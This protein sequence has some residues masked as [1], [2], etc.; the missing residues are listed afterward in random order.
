MT[1]LQRS[2]ATYCDEPAEKELYAAFLEAY[3]EEAHQAEA[4][5]ILA[6]NSFM[7]DLHSRLVP[8]V[9][10]DDTFWQRYF[11]RF[12][13]KVCLLA[14]HLPRSHGCGVE[15]PVHFHTSNTNCGHLQSRV[16]RC[17][18]IKKNGLHKCMRS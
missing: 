6:S 2:G 15:V 18:H 5:E 17:S 11:F 13:L 4:E 3:D 7:A 12:A 9:I 1:Q 14:L 8:L 10:S 16:P